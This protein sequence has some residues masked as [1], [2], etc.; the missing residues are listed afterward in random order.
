MSEEMIEVEFWMGGTNSVRHLV[1]R[2]DI[3]ACYALPKSVSRFKYWRGITGDSSIA[4]HVLIWDPAPPAALEM[5]GEG[6]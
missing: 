3:G 4:G 5:S 2:E 6:K 1:R